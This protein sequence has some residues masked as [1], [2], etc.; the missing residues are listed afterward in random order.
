MSEQA[1]A[2]INAKRAAQLNDFG[3]LRD[4]KKMPTDIDGL[5]EYQNKAY[6]LMEIKYGDKEIPIGQRI[7]L[8]RMAHDFDRLGKK[9]SVILIEHHIHDTN[10]QV[11]V[12]MCRVREIYD[13]KAKRWRQPKKELTAKQAVDAFYNWVDSR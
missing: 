10:K 6:L 11:P 8:E 1:S 4:G 13:V 3:G 9:T 7:A 5:I 2:I 12:A